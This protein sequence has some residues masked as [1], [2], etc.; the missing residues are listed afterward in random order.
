MSDRSDLIRTGKRFLQMIADGYFPKEIMRDNG[1]S[2]YAFWKAV[3]AAREAAAP[4]PPAAPPQPVVDPD[5]R[6]AWSYCDGELLDL[7]RQTRREMEAA[8]RRG[9]DPEKGFG[10]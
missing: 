5:A 1:V 7:V 4:T 8:Q 6:A 9:W 3:T 2:H 10:G